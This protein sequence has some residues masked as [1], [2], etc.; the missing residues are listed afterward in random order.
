MSIQCLSWVL[1]HSD[2]QHG[3]RHVLIALANHADADGGRAFPSVDRLAHESRL[4]RR[5]VQSGLKR[6]KADGA[7]RDEG[8]SPY[9]TTVYRVVMG[10][11]LGAEVGAGGAKNDAGGGEESAQGGAKNDAETA[12]HSSPEP[13][14]NRPG[15]PSK[16]PGATAGAV[17]ADSPDGLFHYWAGKL[18]LDGRRLTPKRKSKLVARLKEPPT[19]GPTR[20]DDIRAAIDFIAG[21]TWHRENGHI[22]LTLICRS[23]EQLDAYLARA[24]AT[25]GGPDLSEYDRAVKRG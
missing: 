10:R 21:S 4:T 24:G 20:A 3:A 22:D 6:L 13:S 15:N 25:P 14:N 11:E 5:A 12:S 23:P 2:A 1:E 19:N 17:D 9:G 7:I 16:E 18:G 8:L